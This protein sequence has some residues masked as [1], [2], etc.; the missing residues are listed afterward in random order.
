MDNHVN[1]L[2]L[3]TI[4]HVLADVN[5]AG[6]TELAQSPLTRLLLKRTTRIGAISA[7]SGE[8]IL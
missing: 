8:P 1:K 3:K 5:L 4:E 6:R 7:D 2:V